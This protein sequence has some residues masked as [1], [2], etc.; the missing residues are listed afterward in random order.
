LSGCCVEL[1]LS[2]WASCQAFRYHPPPHSPVAFSF[3][4]GDSVNF[5]SPCLARFSV[6]HSSVVQPAGLC[7]PLAFF[8]PPFP[9]SLSL[10]RP[11]DFPFHKF[12]AFLPLITEAGTT[13]WR[14]RPLSP[15]SGLLVTPKFLCLPS[16]VAR[17]K[18]HCVGVALSAPQIHF[19][20]ALG[21]P[22]TP[23]RS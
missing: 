18:P 3:F 21:P 6:P 23:P 13:C 10:S 9:R 2:K 7:G 19:F 20:F 16:T 1:V 14:G 22:C 8:F 17:S 5:F 15:N 11:Y 12:S 4:P